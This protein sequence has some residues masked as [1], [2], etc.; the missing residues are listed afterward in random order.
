MNFKFLALSIFSM[1]NPYKMYELRR[2]RTLDVLGNRTPPGFN[3]GSPCTI[4][5]LRCNLL[6]NKHWCYLFN[7]INSHNPTIWECLQP[8]DSPW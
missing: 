3:D 1:R 7:K 4:D 6:L 5:D 8:M 2:S